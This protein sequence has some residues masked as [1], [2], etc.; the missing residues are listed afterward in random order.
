MAKLKL[1]M[2]SGVVTEDVRGR[3]DGDSNN[4]RW[5]SSVFGGQDARMP[6]ISGHAMHIDCS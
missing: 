5:F 2:A 6:L 4:S 1:D 3:A